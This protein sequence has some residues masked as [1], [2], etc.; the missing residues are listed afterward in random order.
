MTY[1]ELI[2]IL[3][4]KL[5]KARLEKEE[6]EKEIKRLKKERKRLIYEIIKNYNSNNKSMEIKKSFKDNTERTK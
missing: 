2:S 6:L 3:S 5:N 4:R 1:R